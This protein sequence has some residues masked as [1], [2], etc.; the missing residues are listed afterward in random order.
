MVGRE[1]ADGILA[2]ADSPG[3]VRWTVGRESEDQSGFGSGDSPAGHK[4]IT[5]NNVSEEGS[6]K[7]PRLSAAESESLF[8]DFDFNGLETVRD[9]YGRDI[10][11]VMT[12]TSV[13]G[14]GD[15]SERH[16]GAGVQVGVKI[17]ARARTTATAQMNRTDQ[18]AHSEP[19]STRYACTAEC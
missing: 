8:A 13:T 11:P 1:Q 4:H 6:A 18:D 19:T 14:S 5:P 12:Q 16:P 9:A 17:K 7:T 10:T 3:I 2:D 15:C